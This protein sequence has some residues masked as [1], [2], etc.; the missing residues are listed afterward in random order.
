MPTL[1]KLIT[2][3]AKKF[4]VLIKDARRASGKTLEECAQFLK[5]SS[6][7]YEQYESG[8]LSPSLPE[9]ESLA[10][11]LKVPVEHFW[12]K[13]AISE[14][15]KPENAKSFERI[16]SLRHRIIGTALRQARQDAGLS[17]VGLAEKMNL[18][19]EDLNVYELGKSPIP[20]PTLEALAGLV[21][22]PLEDFFANRGVAGTGATQQRDIQQDFDLPEELLSFVTKPVNRPYL[23]LAQRLSEM[24]VE[25]LRSVAEGLLEI[26]L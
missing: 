26:T 7:V 3:R 6:D 4:S 17:L 1:N 8:W 18:G 14:R 23:E 9:I 20:L 16:S 25:K 19:T 2:I 15:E 22:K 13:E 10:Y 12:G 11:Y 5:I 21:N 24:S